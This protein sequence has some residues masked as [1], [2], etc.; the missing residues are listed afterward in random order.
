MASPSAAS[1]LSRSPWNEDQSA[2]KQQLEELEEQ[3]KQIQSGL[4]EALQHH[5]R[6][7]ADELQRC[8]ETSKELEKAL[9]DER[10]QH[11]EQIKEWE[12][13]APKGGGGGSATTAR[14]RT[15]RELLKGLQELLQSFEPDESHDT[16][17]AKPQTVDNSDGLLCALKHL[18]QQAEKDP[19]NLLTRLYKQLVSDACDGRLTSELP[20]RE[21]SQ[22]QFTRKPATQ[23]TTPPHGRSWASVAAQPAQRKLPDPKQTK[24][25]REKTQIPYRLWTE[26]TNNDSVTT[27]HALRTKLEREVKQSAQRYVLAIMKLQLNCAPW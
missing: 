16:H 10:R 6:L 3:Q 13:V 2:L 4:K 19:R 24:I 9:E 12:L 23:S 21:V 18:I 15:E 20:E 8:Q 17:H 26:P 25:A 11:A 27:V 22:S 5:R 1:E 7:W 14:K